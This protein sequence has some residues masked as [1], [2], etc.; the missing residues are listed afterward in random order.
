MIYTVKQINILDMLDMYGEDSCREILSSF[1][2]P[3]NIDVADFIHNKAIEFAK[4]RIAITFLVF[5]ETE[6][7]NVLT[8]YYT[9]ANKFVAVSAD[10]LSQTLKKR[11]AKFSQY[12]AVLDRYLIS[13]PLIAQLGRNY[14]N[15]ARDYPISGNN[16]L[17]LA[18]QNIKKVQHII[19][20]KTTY[21]ECASNPK[22]REFYSTH[23]FVPFGERERELD[24]LADSPILVQMLR[25]FKS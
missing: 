7:G 25:Y 6:K 12:D 10:M 22:L 4:Q 23:D 9:L 14:S 3:L 16:L 20:G 13:M 11:I 15:I 5:R 19:G 1:I 18:C 17:D 2:C 24:E 8:G 21:I